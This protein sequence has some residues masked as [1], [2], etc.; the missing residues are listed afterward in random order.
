MHEMILDLH[1]MMED[2]LRLHPDHPYKQIRFHVIHI[3]NQA[4]GKDKISKT[5]PLVN[6]LA[7]PIKT[8]LGSY[9][10][11]TDFNNIRLSLYLSE[12]NKT[13]STFHAINLYKKG[14]TDFFQ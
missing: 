6:D 10:S 9:E 2:T 5:H 12:L 13:D 4:D 3:S 1:A 11:Q 8:I 7:A 14:E